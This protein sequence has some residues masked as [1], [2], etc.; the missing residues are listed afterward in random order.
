[1][2]KV[3]SLLF[4][5]ALKNGDL[6][7]IRRISKSDLHNHFSLGG[8]RDYIN[9]MTGRSIQPL[10]QVLKSMDEMHRW[11]DESY[12]K[13]FS[14]SEMRRLLVEAC[15]VQAQYDGVKLLEVGEDVW[16]LNEYF[17]N[18]IRSLISAFT[19]ANQKYA[20]DTKLRLQI[21]LSRH[22]GIS[23][24]EKVIEPFWG[25]KDFYSIDLYSDEMA[26][27]IENFKNIY[28]KAKGNGLNT[29][30]HV[31]EWGSALDVVK[32]VE[33]LELDEVQHGIA[34]AHDVYAIDFIKE[35]GVR[36]N[37]TPTSNVMLGRVSSIKEHPIRI[38]FDKG[39]DVTINSDD[40]LMF[41]SDISKEYLRL[42]QQGV[43]GADE[44][45]HIR[46]NGLR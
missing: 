42:Y 37:L 35:R 5:E 25:E 29:K 16:A 19:E 20:P 26:Q 39:V 44:L 34:V 9:K 31:G 43:L 24:L 14:T 41:D 3:E 38:L 40:V 27:P 28:K 15:F 8:N 45:D 17:N 32:A 21:G 46:L 36:L 10:K 33:C 2:N 4:K 7:G 12:G 1:M 22:C 30:V 23:Y 18:D 13:A 11:T 6:E